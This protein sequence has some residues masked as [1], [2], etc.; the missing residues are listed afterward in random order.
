MLGV[1][2]NPRYLSI[3]R[4]FHSISI[5][6]P[7]AGTYDLSS[8]QFLLRNVR[9]AH[10]PVRPPVSRYSAY[11]LVTASDS[12]LTSQPAMTRIDVSITNFSPAVRI[13]GLT[14]GSVEMRD[15]Q[16]SVQL[17]RAAQQ[18][19]VLEDTA[20]INSVSIILTNPVDGSES[21]SILDTSSLPAAIT[22]IET[23][24]SVL[25]IGPATPEEFTSALTS[26]TLSYSYPAMESILQGEIPPDFTRR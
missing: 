18:T 3:Q 14:S 15:G 5:T 6:Q 22:V 1:S 21:I 26:A 10:D 4:T 12:Q 8:F 16:T 19:T 25:L 7:A 17:L 24:V 2:T 20:V 9:F 23:G 13:E 11:I